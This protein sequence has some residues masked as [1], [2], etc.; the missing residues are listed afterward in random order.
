MTAETTDSAL[1]PA[2]RPNLMRLK[3]ICLA[4][5]VV[6]L[7]ADLWSKAYMQELLGLWPDS[8][9]G[10]MSREEPIELLD[11]GFIGLAWEGTWNPGITFGLAPGQTT[12]ILTLTIVATLGL[13]VWFLGS[14]SRSKL[15]HVGLALIIGGALGNLY[16]RVQWHKVR[17]FILMWADLGSGQMNWPNYN[18]A[19]MCIV[20]GVGFI[21]WDS[22]FGVGA[23]EAELSAQRRKAK[24]AERAEQRRLE[25]DRRRAES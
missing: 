13:L 5:L 6:A 11:L 17:D 15:L 19:D 2:A 12:V 20:F 3:L 24:K 25:E 4:V 10:R 22:L 9:G 1:A 23:K 18:V 8:E 21:V 7:V 14:R 16:D